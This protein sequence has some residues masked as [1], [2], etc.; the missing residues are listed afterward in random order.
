MGRGFAVT[1]NH[2]SSP[3]DLSQGNLRKWGLTKYDL[4]KEDDGG[5]ISSS[6]GWD[7][8]FFRFNKYVVEGQVEMLNIGNSSESDKNTFIQEIDSLK[9][10]GNIYLYQ[11]GSGI[12]W[13][14]DGKISLANFNTDDSGEMKGGGFGILNKDGINYAKCDT[15]QNVTSSGISFNYKPDSSFQN[16]ITSGDSGSGIY[17][18]DKT[19]NKWILLGVVSQTYV[20]LGL[21]E[22]K[23]SFVS[24][25]E[26]EQ[27][28]KSFEQN[29]KIVKQSGL[30]LEKPMGGQVQLKGNDTPASFEN[31][32]DIIFSGNG[33]IDIE[34]K[35]DIDRAQSGYAGGFVF[36]AGD[37][38]TSANPTTYKFTNENG[39]TYSFRGSGLDIGGNVV[40]EWHLK[41]YKDDKKNEVDSLHKIGKGELIIKTANTETTGLGTL[42]IGEGKVTL[43]TDKRAF[44]NIYITSGRGELALMQGKAEAL[45]ASKNTARGDSPNTNSYTLSQDSA[46]NMGFYFGT[47]GGKLDLVGNSLTLNTIAANDSGATITSATKA[48]LEIQ[49]FGYKENGKK[50]STKKDTIIHASIGESDSANGANQANIDIIH[51]S[52]TKNESAHLIFDGNI[53]TSGKLSADKTN[54]ALQGHA[55]AH[56]TISDSAIRDKVTNAENGTSKGMPNYMDLSKPSTLTQPDWDNRSFKFGN[57]DLKSANL[58]LGRNATLESNITL[59]SSSKVEFGGGVTHFIDTKD[60]KN[61]TGGGFSYQQEVESG[62]IGDEQ[63]KIANRTISYKGKITANGGSIQSHIWDFNASLDLKNSANLS[64]DYLTL[65]NSDSVSLANGAS[66]TIQNLILKNVSENNLNTIFTNSGG[67]KLEV[68]KSFWFDNSTLNLNKLDSAHIDKT[69]NY[70]IVG[71]K[72]TI[73]GANSTLSANVELFDNANLSLKSLTLKNTSTD[74][75]DSNTLKNSVY[76]GNNS[77]SN[78]F[79]K[80]SLT[81]SLK[82][83]N[84]EKA[85]IILSGKSEIIAPKIEFSGVKNGI[86]ALDSEAKLT[87]ANGN[88]NV[89]VS[90]ENSALQIGMLGDKSFNLNAQGGSTIFLLSLRGSVSNEAIQDEN[91]G[92]PRI[93]DGNSRNDEVGTSANFSGN[94]TAKDSS[95]IATALES[96][97][98]SV[99]LSGSAHLVAKNIELK[100]GFDSIKL[101]G[102]SKLTANIITA[103]NLANLTLN[104]ANSANVNIASFIFENSTTNLT[105][106]LIG[107]NIELKSST[108]KTADLSFKHESTLTLDS[109]SKL[110][111]TNLKVEGTNLTLNFA[112]S[113]TSTANLTNINL[114]NNANLTINSWDFG[115]KTAFSSNGDNSRVTFQNAT[116][117]QNS[118]PK[119]IS[120]DST[121]SQMLTLDKVGSDSSKSNDRFETLKFENKN[122]TFGENAKVQVRLDSSVKK[123]E[124]SI[125]L[126][127]YYTLISAG[128]IFDNRAD[129]RIDFIFDDSIAENQKFFIVSKFIDNKLQIKFLESAPNTFDELN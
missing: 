78:D 105:G 6:Y 41:N 104:V 25:K 28:Q 37:S 58:T 52:D 86:L 42:K 96:I 44:D 126:G 66:A 16:L 91:S 47:G 90:G 98:A 85:Q 125:T 2:V 61:V 50:D 24:S 109:D 57:I 23:I 64:A 120:V 73:T 113:A 20:Q 101:S 36:V 97:T 11:A 70:D 27:Y 129:S 63:T 34:I 13:L 14:R 112:D 95:V 12:V 94:I 106:N 93:A 124:S 103:K 40:V 62:S 30:S 117:T 79:T 87:G 10:N 82:A 118:T 46:N 119:S 3:A 68:K 55:T 29:I 115:N 99:D 108:L 43:D 107:E 81:E 72:S 8:K 83:E 116:Y 21:D 32:K 127:T 67:G 35:T 114:N 123:G 69:A 51:S 49:G 121:I 9:D 54:I 77:Q 60:G 5:G 18:Y 53:N 26:L 76:L 31:N 122:L 71:V 45:G 59:D 80:L 65:T 110:E 38:A 128:S 39:K 33:T 75:S 4:A 89:E 92:L 1:A 17:A 100:N 102:D 56:A 84:L 111:M 48:T 19:N 7:T 22:A 88:A 15:C 74:S